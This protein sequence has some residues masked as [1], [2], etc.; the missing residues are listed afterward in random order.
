[1]ADPTA[2][3]RILA[4]VRDYRSAHDY[5]PTLREVA[6]G[7][8]ITSTSVVA[9]HLDKL[10]IQGRIRRTPGIARSI[11]LVEEEVGE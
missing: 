5:G 2:R 6:D 3:P 11:V 9:Y 10:A 7:C 8:G 4:F 1:M